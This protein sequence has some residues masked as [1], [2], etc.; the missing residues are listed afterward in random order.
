MILF[1]MGYVMTFG[2][3]QKILSRISYKPG[4]MLV[5]KEVYS[6]VWHLWTSFV[7]IDAVDGKPVELHGRVW[8]VDPTFN[9][10]ALINTVFM[11]LK[12]L[13]EH[14]LM[15]FFKVDGL[16]IYNSHVSISAH[17]QAYRECFP[18]QILVPQ[19]SEVVQ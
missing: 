13:E 1:I 11:M 6:D 9:E 16:A 2:E 15:E 12:Q 18:P 8:L 4:Y 5:L 17:K 3:A 14:E 10:D 19:A 7:T